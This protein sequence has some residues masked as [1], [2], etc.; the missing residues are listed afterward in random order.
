MNIAEIRTILSQEPSQEELALIACDARS[1]VQKLYAAY[2]RRI[3]TEFKEKE[4]FDKM[5]AFEKNIGSK[6]SQMLPELTKQG[7]D[8]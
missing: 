7:A 1:G 8:R 2:K 4:R 6:E 5:L 3:E